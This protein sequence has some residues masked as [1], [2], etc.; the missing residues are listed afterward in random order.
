M[1]TKLLEDVSIEVS[2]DG[3]K[4]NGGKGGGAGVD[5]EEEEE[6]PQHVM[7]VSEL[8]AHPAAMPLGVF[9]LIYAGV[10]W[11]PYTFLVSY[12]QEVAFLTPASS[13]RLVAIM[14][15]SSTAGR[16]I[17]GR[18][19]QTYP[20]LFL[21]Q[22]SMVVSGLSVVAL[23]MLPAVELVLVLVAAFFGFFAGSV[24]ALIAPILVDLIGIQNLPLGFGLAAAVQSPGVFLCPPVIGWLRDYTGSYFLPFLLPGLVM[25]AGAGIIFL[26][27]NRRPR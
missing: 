26:I 12:S 25:T 17:I 9:M 6:A 16:L 24:V 15:L 22:L 14:G 7:T 3:G 10:L 13:A 11:V 1:C 21:I 19:A 8:L 5:K 2:G 4:E 18:A 27:P 20:Q 23:A